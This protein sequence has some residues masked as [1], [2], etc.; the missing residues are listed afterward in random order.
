MK[1]AWLI[2]LALALVALNA[3]STSARAGQ[4]T[5]NVLLAGGSEPNTVRISLSEDGR[6]YVID[7]SGPLELGSDICQNPP[8]NP[9]E[10]ICQAVR[11][12]GFEV[13]ASGGEDFVRVA[14]HVKVSVTMRG[15]PGRDTL[16]GGAGDDKLIGGDGPDKLIGR[17]GDDTVNGGEGY[18][19]LFGGNGDDILRGGPDPDSLAGGAGENKLVQS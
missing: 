2:A 19:A 16:I 8:G 3:P 13:N 12:S 1:K 11:V 6:S 4:L 10:L 15:G 14:R 17:D 9:N 5:Y 18:D 7:S